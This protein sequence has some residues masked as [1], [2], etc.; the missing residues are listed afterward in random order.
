MWTPK[1]EARVM[2]ELTLAGSDRVLEIGTGSGYFCA[3]LA[4]EAA[5]VTSV[6]I[7]PDLAAD[8]REKLARLGP[9]TCGSRSAMV[10]GATAA[11][12]TMSSC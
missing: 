1:M 5:E 8:A 4:S 2:Q 6:E 10:R 11:T 12:P 3:L 9:P 7:D